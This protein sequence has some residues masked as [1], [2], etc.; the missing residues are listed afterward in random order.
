MWFGRDAAKG[1]FVVRRFVGV[2]G[3]FGEEL[4][5]VAKLLASFLFPLVQGYYCSAVH[6]YRRMIT[7]V[8]HSSFFSTLSAMILNC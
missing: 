1:V 8:L 7:Q 3:R 6:G 4:G 2:F 5:E